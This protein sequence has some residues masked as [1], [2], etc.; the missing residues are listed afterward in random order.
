MVSQKLEVVERIQAFNRGRSPELLQ[1]KYRSM[2]KDAFTFFRGTCHLFYEDWPTE[3]PLNEAPPVW[4]C[5]DLHLENFGSYKGD[6]RLVYFDMNDFDEAAL[7]PCIWEVARFLTS[8]LVGATALEV[9]EAESLALCREGLETYRVTLARGQTRMVERDTATGLVKELLTSLKERSRRAFLD[10][11]TTLTRTGRK[12]QLDPK[13]TRPVTPEERTRIKTALKAWSATQPDPGFFKLLDVA[14]RIAGTGSLGIE[15]YVLLVEGRGS[16]HRNYVLDLKA[17]FASSLQPYLK[18]L[19]PKW[20]NE[21]ER[22]V[23]IQARMQGTPPALRSTLEIEGQAYH[24]R[25]LQPTEDRINLAQNNGRLSRLQKL[26][27]TMAQITAWNQLR[28][29]G[30]QGSAIADDLIAFAQAST[31]SEEMLNY[32]QHYSA[33]VKSDYHA[34]CKAFESGSLR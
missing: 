22:V 5:G 7:A 11:R 12:L 4:I 14:H 8:L 6:N 9:S 30:R 25:E 10:G 24:L 2:S 31:W 21:A 26:I 28:S 16:P 1:L 29:G 17:Q 13:R 20:A 32:A 18:L 23:S 33:Q 19:Q 15:R 34:F 3:T 27:K